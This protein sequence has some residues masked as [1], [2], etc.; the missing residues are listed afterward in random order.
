MQAAE[1]LRQHY[2]RPYFLPQYSESSK[3]DWIFMGSPGYGAH[4]HVGVSFD[5]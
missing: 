4:M 1:K 5:C 2:G 3:V